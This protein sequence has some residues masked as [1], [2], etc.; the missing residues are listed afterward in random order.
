MTDNIKEEFWDRLEDARVGMLSAGAARAVPM[1]HYVDDDHPEQGIWFIT[2][3]Q[4]DLAQAA[5]AGPES[6]F[7]VNSTGQS[8]YAR[9]DGT[10]H[11]SHDTAQLD[12]LWNFVADA[13]FEGG[14]QDPDVQ[15][16]NFKPTTAEIWVT[17]GSMKFLYEVAKANLTDSKPDMG[18]HKVISF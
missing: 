1:S 16:L 12:R 7:I 17:G 18:E 5:A 3:K 6:T 10:L 13:W 11:L 4:T 9:I 2:A 8:L 15:L 14:K